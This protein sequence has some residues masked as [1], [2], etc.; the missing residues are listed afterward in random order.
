MGDITL[1][2]AN[3]L[4]ASAARGNLKDLGTLLRDIVENL[5]GLTP[6]E[7]D[8]IDGLT[9]G[10]T[11]ASKALVVGASKDLDTLTVTEL[12]CDVTDGSTDTNIANT[13]IT[14]LP[15]TGAL[16]YTMD[17]PEAG[18]RAVVTCTAS[19]TASKT[20]TLAFG[21]FDG[22]NN[23]ATF[24]AAAETLVVDGVSSGLF[25]VSSNVGSVGLSS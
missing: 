2:K 20:V 8:L 14:T 6:A 17:G 24:D 5:E 22:T 16:A 12:K 23:I 15:S 11:T 3:Q 9:A 10:T 4:A 21:T 18:N 25:A 13:G 7:L 19:D 1:P